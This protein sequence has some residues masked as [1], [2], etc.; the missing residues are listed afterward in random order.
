[1]KNLIQKLTQTPGPSG[2]EQEIRKVIREEITPL[3]KSIQVDALGSL[4]VRLGEKKPGGLRV[5]VAAH[6]DE[7][8]VMV[9]H[10]E[11]KGFVRFSNLGTVFPR[12]LAGGRVRFLNGVRGV[13]NH[14]R[15][16]D[17][18][19]IPGIEKF[20]IDV[21]ATSDKDCSVKVGDVAV[22]D[23]E[24][25]DMGKRVSSKAMDDRVACAVLIETMRNIK[26][27]P[28]ELVFVFSTQ[29]E[30]QSRGAQTAAYAIEAD[31]GLAVDVTPT[32]DI[33]GVK[34]QVYLGQG[35]A[36]KVRDAGMIA[37][38]K[39]VKWMADT[40]KKNQIPCQMEVL[41]VGSTDARTMQIARSGML[42]GALSIPCR[43]VHS[44]SELVDMNDVT[45]TVKLL[46]ALLS[47]R[48]Q[49]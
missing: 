7:I 11:K 8:G 1:M 37:D 42:T 41:D 20:F 32:G 26:T 10:V 17:L 27:T 38:P 48:I 46:T 13:I 28:N 4:I 3:A 47:E 6:M 15:P 44:P 25:L 40:A 33:L 36:I 19:K 30:V 16:E 43:Y 12:Y 18:A 34:M 31:L 35:P 22:F 45:Q 14:D 9:N 5:M 21:G 29:E 24:F 23:R 49:L 39:V 2:Y